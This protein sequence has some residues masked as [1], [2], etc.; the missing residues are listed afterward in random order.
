[1]GHAQS[2]IV[3]EPGPAAHFLVLAASDLASDARRIAAKLARLDQLAAEVSA[4]VP[5]AGLRAVVAFGADFW[6]R[7]SPRERPRE[8]KRFRSIGA[9]PLVAPATGGDVL[10]HVVANRPDVA[11]EL[12]RRVRLALGDLV[13]PLDEVA[14]FRYLDGRD[15]TGFIDGTENPAGDERA[16]AALI[17][18]EDAGFEGGSYVTAHRYVHDL[19]RWSALGTAEQERIIGRTKADSVELDDSVR[20]NDSHVSRV[21]IEEDGAELQIVRHSF[22]YGT[23]SEAGLFFIAYSRT[24]S[25]FEKMLQRMYGTGGDGAHDRLMEFTRAVSGGYFFAP[26]VERVRALAEPA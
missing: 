24:I 8:L 15:L 21:V 13:R 23:T 14:G 17:G 4:L 18:A 19:V 16:V 12:A 2:G 22:P 6:E 20:P 7:V 3:P 26:S 10:L 11:F 25:T 9:G 5:D 1:M